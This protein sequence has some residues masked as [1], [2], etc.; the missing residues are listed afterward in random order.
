MFVILGIAVLA[1]VLA[2]TAA[3]AGTPFSINAS[4]YSATAAEHASADIDGEIDISNLFFC[5]SGD[6]AQTV[7]MYELSEDTNTVN[8]IM[9]FVIPASA[10]FYRPFGDLNYNDR[11]RIEDV[12]FRK[13][14]TSSTV[15]ANGVYQ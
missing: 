12:I 13:S 4:T 11:I 10:G 7:T 5:N 6:T 9:T 3:F 8:S 14:S 1:S 2:P 15:Y